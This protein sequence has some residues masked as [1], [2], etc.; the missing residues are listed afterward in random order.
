MR[1]GVGKR[2]WDRRAFRREQGGGE[3]HRCR[4]INEGIRRRIIQSS[5]ELIREGRGQSTGHS[6]TTEARL[7][8]KFSNSAPN[9]AIQIK[10]AKPAHAS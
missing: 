2:C 3:S 7:V 4:E 1:L 9:H 5:N 8:S 10:T 6:K